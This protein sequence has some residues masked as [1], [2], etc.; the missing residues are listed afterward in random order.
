MNPQPPAA[1]GGNDLAPERGI[2]AANWQSVEGVLER[3]G[4]AVLPALL[5]AAQCAEVAGCFPEEA[6]FRSR[7]VMD[8]YAFGRGEYT[9]FRYPLPQRVERLRQVLCLRLA[10]IANRWQAR[11]RIDGRFPA[12]HAEFRAICHAAGQKD[13][14]RCCCATRRATIV[15][16][17]RIGTASAHSRSRSSF[18]STGLDVISAAGSCC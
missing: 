15:A 4:F 12:S 8:R 10:P 7:I 16:C 9:Y 11:L 5:T 17:T 6:R 3:D 2:D 14:R 1:A 13:R 18:C